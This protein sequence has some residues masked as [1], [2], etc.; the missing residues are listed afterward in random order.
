MNISDYIG[1]P[2]NIRNERGLNCFGLVA[3][4]YYDLFGDSLPDYKANVEDTAVIN[5]IFTNAFVTGDHGFKQVDKPSDYCVVV[6]KRKSLN[7]FAYH[8]GLIYKNKVLHCHKAA[9]GVVYQPIE[10]A[11]RGYKV[12]EFWQ[13]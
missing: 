1:I 4:V 10:Q 7:S 12:V 11:K 5:S 13:R 9:G 2:Y 6:F 3:K 8:C